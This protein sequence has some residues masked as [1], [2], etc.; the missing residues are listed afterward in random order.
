MWAEPVLAG[1]LLIVAGSARAIDVAPLWD[2]ARPAVSEERF[3]AAM[4]SATGDDALILQ[5]Q[6][7]RTYVFRKDFARAREL[8]GDV[9]G[10]LGAA[11]PEA[12]ARYW[13]ELGRTH[14]SHQHPPETQTAEAKRLARDAFSR[15]L[16]IARQA[17]LDAMAIDAL[18][19]FPFVDTA[20]ADQLR[21]TQQALALVEA[22]D[23]A[24]AKRWEPSIRSNIG[25]AL[26]DLGRHGEALEQF[27]RALALY[28]QGTDP[29]SIR[30]AH[31]QVART[32]R[33]LNRIDDALAIQ[34][35]VERESDQAG[36]PKAYVFEELE[37]LY[38]AKG[39]GERARHYADRTR[40]L[41]K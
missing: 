23:Q 35:R 41:S 34:L 19:M 30:D 28:E 33:A 31:W 21:W 8:L 14:A 7:A 22:S 15:A 4:K 2:H 39:D 24:S 36:A 37:L 10:K 5:T 20:T 32:L 40:L 16:R 6:I 1:A 17:R 9:E 29:R 25:E 13:L 26:R 27:K 11:G 38:Q 3:R 12:Q 18:H